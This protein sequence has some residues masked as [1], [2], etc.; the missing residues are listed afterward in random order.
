MERPPVVA[1]GDARPNHTAVVV[2]PMEAPIALPAVR[3]TRGTPYLAR[4]A[5]LVAN[6]FTAWPDPYPLLWPS[7]I[8]GRRGKTL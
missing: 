7:A 3:C 6:L 4:P 8:A 2:E 5:P 1:L